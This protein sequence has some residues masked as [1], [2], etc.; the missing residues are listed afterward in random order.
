MW[1]KRDLLFTERQGSDQEASQVRDVGQVRASITP[2]QEQDNR[3][4][5]DY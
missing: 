2:H 1:G 4:N 3:L 5:V